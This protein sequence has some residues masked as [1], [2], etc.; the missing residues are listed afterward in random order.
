MAG[1]RIHG[2]ND[3]ILGD[4]P[5]DAEHA[6]V[7]FGDVLTS[8]DGQQIRCVAGRPANISPSNTASAASA[9]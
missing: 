3:P 9:S 6:V 2:G 1:L 7:A 8:D 4:T 5:H